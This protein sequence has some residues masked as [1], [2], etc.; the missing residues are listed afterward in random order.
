M[1]WW[2]TVRL[3]AAWALGLYLARMYVEMGWVKFDPN[4]FWT[5]AFERWGY[6]TWL[7]WVVGIIET[8]GGL[9]LLIPWLATYG[10]LAVG[11]VM[12]GA[13][14]TRV[15]D[16]R[17]VDVAWISGYLVALGWIAFEWRPFRL[18]GHRRPF[19]FPRRSK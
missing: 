19:P 16:H 5:T 4:G 14:V 3:V 6:P 8:L 17:M 2:K 1:S 13:W 11:A 9:M 12:T 10:A 18:G 15:H 7:R